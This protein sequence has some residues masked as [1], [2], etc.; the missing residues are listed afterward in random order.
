VC[1][2][3]VLLRIE[4]VMSKAWERLSIT[5]GEWKKLRNM[6]R[7]VLAAESVYK[8]FPVEKFQ[9]SQAETFYEKLKEEAFKDL[10][11]GKK[12]M[13]EEDLRHL[14]APLGTAF[15]YFAFNTYRN[16]PLKG[17]ALV[18]ELQKWYPIA[19]SEVS[20]M[21][22]KKEALIKFEPH[23]YDFKSLPIKDAGAKKI[24][25]NPD[26]NKKLKEFSEVSKSV[27]AELETAKRKDLVGARSPEKAL[28]KM[29]DSFSVPSLQAPDNLV[30]QKQKER[31]IGLKA[32]QPLKRKGAR[33]FGRQGSGDSSDDEKSTDSTDKNKSSSASGEE[34]SFVAQIKADSTPEIHVP[35]PLTADGKSLYAS[36]PG[37]LSPNT[38]GR[39]RLL[40][41]SGI[42][43]LSDDFSPVQT[44][45]SSSPAASGDNDAPTGML[46]RANA[47]NTGVS[48]L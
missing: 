13:A 19:V 21:G 31:E 15:F 26:V 17:S 3:N 8:L 20:A 10:V 46:A 5:E 35:D 40:R 18:Q 39:S 1:R 30:E 48:R 2:K 32:S 29:S 6:H 7:V 25:D 23:E 37:N 45:S 42:R 47:S 41:R 22:T 43:R 44:I 34:K 16:L 24:F 36:S 12:A 27:L 38:E 33:V 9:I 11:N 28:K 14:V 4:G